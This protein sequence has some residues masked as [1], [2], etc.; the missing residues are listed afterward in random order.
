M[1]R[2]NIIFAQFTPQE[3]R[4]ALKITGVRPND[5]KSLTGML[6]SSTR[7]HVG[8]HDAIAFLRRKGLVDERVVP[9]GCQGPCGEIYTYVK[10]IENNP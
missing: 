3:L 10:L 4:E 2:D 5:A 7:K 1:S 6:F 9:C 8:M